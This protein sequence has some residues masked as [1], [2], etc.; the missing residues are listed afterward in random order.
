MVTSAQA[1]L[2]WVTDFMHLHYET[3][4]LP[5]RKLSES[6]R[7]QVLTVTLSKKWAHI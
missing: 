4:E 3:A 1:L 5:P 7:A 6:V 2:N